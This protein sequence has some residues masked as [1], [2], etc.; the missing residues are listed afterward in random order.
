MSVEEGPQRDLSWREWLP[1]W[2]RSEKLTVAGAVVGVALQLSSMHVGL[3]LL[4]LLV[5]TTAFVWSFVKW[6]RRLLRRFIWN[7]RNRLVVAFLFI[8]VI[9]LLLVVGLAG[10]SAKETAGQ[11]A[12]YLVH[13]ELDRRIALLNLS[14]ESVLRVG[15]GALERAVDRIGAVNQERFPGL[16]VT[17]RAGGRVVTFPQDAEAIEQTAVRGNGAALVVRGGY[18]FG[19][20]HAVNADREV[21][22]LAPLSRKFFSDLAPGLCEVSV[23]HFADPSSA[24]P[25]RRRPISFHPMSSREEEDE[26]V[27]AV[28]PAINQFDFELLWGTRVP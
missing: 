16:R 14:A 3:V 12:V 13:S 26:A 9:P 11:F 6:A 10:Y 1:C 28:P 15:D 27:Q 25:F 21:T 8:A 4:A 22:L 20:A 17:A 5:T 19:W 23:L 18:L 24:Q 2:E 7:L